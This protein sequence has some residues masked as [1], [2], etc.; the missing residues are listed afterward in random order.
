MSHYRRRDDLEYYVHEQ[1]CVF[2]GIY[3]TDQD[4]VMA[5]VYACYAGGASA[6]LDGPL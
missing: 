4:G 5:I 2:Q 3:C 1:E 6:Q